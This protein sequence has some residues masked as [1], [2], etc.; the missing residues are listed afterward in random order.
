METSVSQTELLRTRFAQQGSYLTSSQVRAEG[1]DLKVIGR[2]I[3]AGEVEQVQ[4]GVYRHT[5]ADLPEH[6]DLIELQL[7]VPYARPTLMTALDLHGLTTTRPTRIQVAIPTNRAMPDLTYPPVQV[8]WYPP[9]VYEAGT[10]SFG[11]PPLTFTAYSPEK[12][13]ADLLRLSGKLGRQPYLEGLANYLARPD[14]NLPEL[15]RIARIDRVEDE[16]RRDLEVLTH[17]EVR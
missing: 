1:I 9:E 3:E 16:L 6:A 4:R 8:Y 12:T 2:M 5:G 10:V 13:I 14:R 15:L 7:R 11:Q 17:D